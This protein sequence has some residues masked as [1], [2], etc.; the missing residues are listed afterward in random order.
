M[1]WAGAA[2][3]RRGR[4]PAR[5]WAG[6]WAGAAPAPRSP[7]L[8][9]RRRARPRPPARRGGVARPRRLAPRRA[10]HPSLRQA[11]AQ[12]E[13]HAL[14]A[15]SRHAH[16]QA[17]PPLR[18]PSSPVSLPPAR[19]SYGLA[20]LS[21]GWR[22]GIRCW[23]RGRVPRSPPA[24]HRRPASRPATR[25]AALT[26]E[27]WVGR[28]SASLRHWLEPRRATTDEQRCFPSWHCALLWVGGDA[29]ARTSRCANP[30]RCASIRCQRR[31]HGCA[32]LITTQLLV[33]NVSDRR[34]AMSKVAQ[35]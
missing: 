30:T 6:T 16:T 26:A 9:A 34:Y 10:P 7:P 4:G 18:F 27:L 32:D 8:P 14:C 20:Q 33:P 31:V 29:A 22:R 25:P 13:A 35:R 17:S 24:R 5:L 21:M 15:A 12:T 2:V 11:S 23:A 3:G 1:P 28:V 19:R